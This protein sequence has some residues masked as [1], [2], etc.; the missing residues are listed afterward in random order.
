MKYV[1]EGKTY[2]GLK[3]IHDE[4]KYL[5]YKVREGEILNWWDTNTVLLIFRSFGEELDG[6][7]VIFIQRRTLG[8]RLLTAF[9]E[10]TMQEK[11]LSVGQIIKRGN[12]LHSLLISYY[13]WFILR[14]PRSSFH[15]WQEKQNYGFKY[16]FVLRETARY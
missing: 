10:T 6:F 12:F 8:G 2:N 4:L 14:V 3:P 11:V 15:L 7:K 5:K 16:E 1:I 9:N 13:E